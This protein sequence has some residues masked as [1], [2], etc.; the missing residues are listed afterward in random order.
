MR[1]REYSSKDY[2]HFESRFF[3]SLQP[4]TSPQNRPLFGI[5]QAILYSKCPEVQVFVHKQP[6]LLEEKYLKQNLMK[7]A[8]NEGRHQVSCDLFI[9][10]HDS[11]SLYRA[12]DL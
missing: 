5:K 8:L 11:C 4:T 1:W 9:M 6:K 10:A 12:S 7:M 2:P 3:P